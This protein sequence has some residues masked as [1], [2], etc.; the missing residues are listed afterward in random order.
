MLICLQWGKDCQNSRSSWICDLSHECHLRCVERT[1]L[2]RA[3][4]LIKTRCRSPPEWESVWFVLQPSQCH[5]IPSVIIEL[6]ST[7]QTHTTAPSSALE[8]ATNPLYELL[9]KSHVSCKGANLWRHLYSQPVE[10]HTSLYSI[11]LTIARHS[12]V[13]LEG[14]FSCNISSAE[15]LPFTGWAAVE[16]PW[17]LQT[18]LAYSNTKLW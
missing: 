3:Q 15:M 1:T 17:R 6:L 2:N 7:A 10:I 9:M 13:C 11:F 8:R 14:F 5:A 16:S 12:L 4:G 18:L